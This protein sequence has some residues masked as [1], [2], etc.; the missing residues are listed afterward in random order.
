MKKDIYIIKN[1]VND[2]VYI[3]Q[4]K[5]AAERWLSH[6]YNAKHEN[7]ISKEKQIIHKAMMKYGIDKF[8]Y[9]ILEYQVSNYDE[10]EIYWIKHF[11]SIVPNGYNIA[12][13]GNGMGAGC[14]SVNSVFSLYCEFNKKA[15]DSKISKIID[16]Y[17]VEKLLQ[18]DI[19]MLNRRCSCDKI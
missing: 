5:D 6:V 2:K 12:V 13:G 17:Q 1:S 8:H 10:R 3:G 14:E 9:E 7:K 18:I 11:N 16:N 15:I 4:A 19:L